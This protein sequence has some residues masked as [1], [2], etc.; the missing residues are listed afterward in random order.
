MSVL[1]FPEQI[2]RYSVDEYEQ[3]VATGTFDG[4]RVELLDGL[5]LDM[6]P[7][8]PAHENVVAWLHEWLSDRIDRDRHQVRATGSLRTESSEPEP[9]ISVVARRRPRASHPTS[10]DLV[11]EV[12]VT[13]QARDLTLKPSVYAPAVAEYWVLDLPAATVVVHRDPGSEGYRDV[14]VHGH[15]A[16]LTPQRLGIEGLEVTAL[17]DA[18]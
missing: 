2:H 7:R 12:A 4:Q 1:D 17:L 5:I 11:I 18:A 13:S 14:T 15:D 6:S 3:L 8:S 10:A 9:D 16:V